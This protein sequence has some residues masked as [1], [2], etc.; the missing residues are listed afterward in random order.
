MVM[1]TP[2]DGLKLYEAELETTGASYVMM[3]AE[4]P[5][6]VETT[7]EA[8]M[9]VLASPIAGARHDRAVLVV[10]DNV[11]HMVAPILLVGVRFEE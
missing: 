3:R 5:V 2:C 7:A 6:R 8:M 9:P 4:V 11:P 1:L 10:Q